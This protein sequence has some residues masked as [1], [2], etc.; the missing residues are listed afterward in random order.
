MNTTRKYYLLSILQIKTNF[1]LFFW[2]L[3]DLQKDPNRVNNLLNNQSTTMEP[4]TMDVNLTFLGGTNYKIKVTRILHP[5]LSK[6]N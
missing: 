4:I 6:A 1:Y 3:E 2:L 5:K